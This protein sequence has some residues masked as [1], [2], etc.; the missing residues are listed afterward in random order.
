MHWTVQFLVVTNLATG[1]LASGAAR[2]EERSG[3]LAVGEPNHD[4]LAAGASLDRAGVGHID[5]L[6][7]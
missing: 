2:L 3:L 7:S 6:L 5:P 4:D 1:R